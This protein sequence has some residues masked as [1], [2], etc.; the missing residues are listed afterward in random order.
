LVVE[1]EA[2]AGDPRVSE[3]RAAGVLRGFLQG[4][5]PPAQLRVVRGPA[6]GL[7][8]EGVTLPDALGVELAPP[9]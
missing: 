8:L 2:G 3:D 7:R 9:R 4:D 1:R 5:V 6:P